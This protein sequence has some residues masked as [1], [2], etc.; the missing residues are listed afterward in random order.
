VMEIKRMLKGM[1]VAWAIGEKDIRIYYLKP[2]SLMFGI[3]FPFSMFLSFLVGRNIPVEQAIP[4]LVAQTLFFASSSIGPVT[5]PLERRLHTFD[6]FLSAPISLST[7]LV[8]KTIAGFIYGLG[9]SVIP[10]IVG[11][12]FFHS[13]VTDVVALGVGMLLSAFGF[14][15]MGIMFASIPG[16]GPGQVMMPLNFVRIPLLFI[17]GVF[18][19]ISNLPFWGQILSMFSPLTHTIELVRSGLGGENVFGPFV[20][21]AVLIVYLVVFLFVGIRFHIINQ[22]KE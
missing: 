14:A 19:P 9:I 17:S 13:I 18:V 16:Q 10:I 21:V 2:A 5:I 20:N 3:L 7:V 4:M 12:L 11:T 8:G 1:R 6:R 15:A 22:K